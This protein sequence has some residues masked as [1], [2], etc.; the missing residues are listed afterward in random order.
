VVYVLLGLFLG[1]LGIHNFYSG[2][3]GTA[4]IQLLITL[5]SGW[6]VI[7]LF[8]VGIWA[9]IEVCTVTADARGVPFQ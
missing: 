7:P 6:L 1:G 2:H 4:V 3:T 8:I 5:L 9:L